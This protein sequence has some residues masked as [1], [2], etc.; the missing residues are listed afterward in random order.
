MATVVFDR[1]AMASWYAKRH[2]TNDPDISEV[3][4]LPAN[5]PDREIRLIEI[6]RS[7]YEM[8]DDSLEPLEFGCDRG[9]EGEHSLIVLDVSADQW[10]RMK[11]GDLAPPEGWSLNGFRRFAE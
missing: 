10:R 11:A 5:A 9:S 4:Y 1:D 6:S 7:P 8:R 2:L 3:I